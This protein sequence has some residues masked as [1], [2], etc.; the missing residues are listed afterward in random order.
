VMTSLYGSE[1]VPKRIFGD[2]KLLD[3]FYATMQESAPAAWELNQTM[4][5]LWNPEKLS[6]DWV[7]PDNFHVHV[8]VMDT[9]S[10]VVHFDDQP[11]DITYKVNQPMEN[12]RSLG[13]NMV[14]SID[15]MIVREMVRRCNYDQS[16]VEYLADLL[17]GGSSL[18]SNLRTKDGKMVQLLWERYR[19]TGY[20]SARIIDHL[21]EDNML[22]VDL[23][24]I[25][26]LLDSL[27][28]KP[29]KVITIHDCFRCLPHY[30]N[31]LRRQYAHQLAL[32]AKS[33]L[34]SSLITQLIGR[35]VQIGKLDP[36]LYAEIVSTNYALS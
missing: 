32:I 25:R 3:L 8:K 24:E 36:T 20:L 26:K 19:S 29:F 34:L 6:N 1:A 15:G 35:P 12:G 27:P 7:M 17:E 31:D 16:K 30:G 4:L 5:Q 13:A 11:F 23:N 28:P 2:G 22:N 33:E 10:D 9:M 21:N 14:H 18:G